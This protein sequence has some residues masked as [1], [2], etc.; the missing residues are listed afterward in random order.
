MSLQPAFGLF[1]RRFEDDQLEFEN[2]ASGDPLVFCPG[3]TAQL[4]IE[5][6]VVAFRQ[7]HQLHLAK[8][9]FFLLRIS[10][11]QEVPDVVVTRF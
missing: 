5:I 9:P 10:F 11:I 6:E 1:G 4:G 8:W 7:R 2:T 3:G